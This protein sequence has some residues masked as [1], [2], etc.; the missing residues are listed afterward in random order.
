MKRLEIVFS[1]ILA[2]LAVQLKI[3]LK[4]NAKSGA[5]M[6]TAQVHY[7]IDNIC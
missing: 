1:L 4:R 3:E 7:N 6:F 5:T 2:R